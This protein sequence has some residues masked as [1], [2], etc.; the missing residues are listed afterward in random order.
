MILTC[1]SVRL[2]LLLLQRQSFHVPQRGGT[3]GNL[4]RG[5]HLYT[6][7]TKYTPAR[8]VANQ[9]RLLQVIQNIGRGLCFVQIWGK[10]RRNGRLR[11]KQKFPSSNFCMAGKHSNG[12]IT[13]S[14]ITGHIYI[15]RFLP[16]T[17]QRRPTC[18]TWQH[19]QLGARQSTMQDM[20]IVCVCIVCVYMYIFRYRVGHKKWDSS[21]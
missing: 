15:S 10:L 19:H 6:A 2:L 9:I 21:P 12:L 4:S 18:T 17:S 1:R 16:Q 20:C 8:N 13:L 14:E 5:L 11:L 7:S 3:K